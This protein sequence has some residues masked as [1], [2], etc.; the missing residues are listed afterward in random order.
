MSRTSVTPVADLPADRIS[1]F[2]IQMCR[3]FIALA[4][5]SISGLSNADLARAFDTSPSRIN[6]CLNT[7]IAVGLA[8][9]LDNG[10]FAMGGKAIGISRAHEEELKRSRA[11]LD[12]L[13]Q[14]SR[15]HSQRFL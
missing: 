5:H 12:E 11:R 15:A 4:G 6:R 8:R 13:D 10:R 7:L 3:V 1:A 14:N 9:K 2:G